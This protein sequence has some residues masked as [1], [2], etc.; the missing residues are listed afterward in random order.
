MAKLTEKAKNEMIALAI[1]TN[2]EMSFVDE[3]PTAFNVTGALKIE[4]VEI[5]EEGVLIKILVGKSLDFGT[6][7]FKEGDTLTVAGVQITTTCNFEN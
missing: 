5:V 3:P 7:L 1:K 2:S 4:L 6:Y